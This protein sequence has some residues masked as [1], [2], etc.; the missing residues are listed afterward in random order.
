MLLD[1]AVPRDLVG[2]Q[3]LQLHTY[4]AMNQTV[5]S[6][7]LYYM[8]RKDLVVP[9]GL[10]RTRIAAGCKVSCLNNQNN[11]VKDLILDDENGS[12]S[13]TWSRQEKNCSRVQSQ[14]PK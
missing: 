8:A 6:K 9:H 5:Q 12:C 14:L 2:G 4:S 7:T 3:E 13:T 1:L 11:E 10:G